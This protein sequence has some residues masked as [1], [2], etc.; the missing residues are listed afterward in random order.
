MY[1]QLIANNALKQNEGL[2]IHLNKDSTSYVKALG[3]AQVWMRYNSNNPGSTIFGTPVKNTFDVGLRRVRYQIMAQINPKV[4]IYTQIGINSFNSIS[5]RKAPVFFHDATV[6]Y[7]FYKNYFTLGTGLHAWNGTARFSSS[8]I[9]SILALDLPVIQETTNDVTDQF[10]RKLGVYAKGK[11]NNF[12]YRISVSNP[13]P[14][15]TSLAKVAT[16]PATETNTAYFS[17]KAPK[18]QYQGYFMWQFFDK[19]S[20]LTPF[21]TGSYLGKKNVFNIGVGFLNQK[22]AMWYRNTTNDT[23][24]TTHTQF[25]VDV[26]YDTP[27]NKDKQTVITAYA[28][29]LSYNFGPNYLRNAG[30]MNSANGIG[31][32]ASFNGAGNSFPLIGTG[33]VVYFQTAYLCKNDLLKNQGTLQPY[34][35]GSYA[36]YEK[37]T[38]PVMVYNIGIN[39][40]QN[41]N[42]SKISLDYQSRPI[43]NTNTNAEIVETKSARRGM[44]VLQYQASF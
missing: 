8:S 39:W 4:F 16:L 17:E 10:V 24:T 36:H 25:G 14:V 30:A 33:K 11:I 21:M 18:L 27:L 41:G 31:N 42:N 1:T 28:S 5:A 2:K 43:F 22:D 12:D 32:G 38:N 44:I 9:A 13:F 34:L 19:E 26:F 37:L 3:L 29:F 6:E 23:I 40:L 15:Q 35:A 7:A 20:N